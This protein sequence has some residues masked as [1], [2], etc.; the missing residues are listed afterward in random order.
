MSTRPR[1]TPLVNCLSRPRPAFSGHIREI[2]VAAWKSN[3]ALR[4][5]VIGVSE[6]A[7]RC[8]RSGDRRHLSVLLGGRIRTSDWLIQSQPRKIL[9]SP[10]GRTEKGAFRRSGS[11]R[12]QAPP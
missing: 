10:L 11:A 8:A 7:E 12:R 2:A 3:D 5:I 1:E 9:E 6:W 4:P